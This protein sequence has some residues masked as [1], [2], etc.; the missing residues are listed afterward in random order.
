MDR[1]RHKALCLR[2]AEEQARRRGPGATRAAAAA[3]AAAAVLQQAPALRAADRRCLPAPLLPRVCRASRMH[4][5]PLETTCAWCRRRRAVAAAAG[6]TAA[7]APAAAAAAPPPQAMSGHSR[8]CCASGRAAAHLRC[9]PVLPPPYPQVMTTNHVVEIMLKWLELRCGRACCCRGREPRSVADTCSA[10]PP[11]RGSRP[12]HL[13]ACPPACIQRPPLLLP[14]TPPR[15]RSNWKA[16][17]ESVI[18]S[19]KRKHEEGEQAEAAATPAAHAAQQQERAEQEQQ[20]EQ[21]SPGGSRRWRCAAA[22]QAGAARGGGKRRRGRGLKQPALLPTA[23]IRELLQELQGQCGG[24][25]RGRV[26]REGVGRS[27]GRRGAR[28]TGCCSRGPRYRLG[29]GQAAT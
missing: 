20:V 21:E 4:G 14:P 17:F 15:A 16:A 6:G 26:G 22:G 19:R 10:R 29:P 3:A 2:K 28:C 25:Y 7:T 11:L 5:C 13:P 1:N 27:C 23:A 8:H 12:P 24:L 9:P 18:P